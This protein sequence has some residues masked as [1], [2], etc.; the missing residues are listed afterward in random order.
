MGRAL[1]AAAALVICAGTPAA[2]LLRPGESVALTLTTEPGSLGTVVLEVTGPGPLAVTARSL[3]LDVKLAAFALLPD[4]SAPEKPLSEDDNGLAGTDARIVLRTNGPARFRLE[5]RAADPTEQARGE[6][7]LEARPGE[8]E[9]PTAEARAQADD[10]YWA[11]V[12]MWGEETSDLSLRFRA[13]LGSVGLQYA[14]GKHDAALAHAR[15]AASLAEQAYGPADGRLGVALSDLGLMLFLSGRY[16]EAAEVLPR[17]V[18]LLEDRYGAEDARTATGLNVL[19]MV[20]QETGEL[21]AAR[22]ALE[23]CLATR[24]RLFGPDASETSTALGNLASILDEMGD[25]EGSLA[26]Y[27][28]SLAII[29]RVHGPQSPRMA[30]ALNNVGYA[31]KKMGRLSEARA[32]YERALAIRESVLGTEHPLYA[33]SLQNLG[34]A[35][36]EMGDRE[37][38]VALLRRALALRER[39]LAPDHPDLAATL[40]NLARVLHDGTL[41]AEALP[42]AERALAIRRVKLGEAHPDTARVQLLHARILSALGRSA[43]AID[44]ALAAE[45]AG[46]ENARAVARFLPERL[47]LR[48]AANRA[49]GTEAAVAAALSSGAPDGAR[50]WDEVV[51]SR[52][53]VLDEMA[54]RRAALRA[55][56]APEVQ[57]ARARLTEAA[58]HWAR[59]ASGPTGKGVAEAIARAGAEREAAERA[60]AEISAAY[61]RERAA[62]DVG[63]AEV[64]RALPADAALVAYVRHDRGLAALVL[65][66]ENKP[67]R[68]V[69]LGEAA[70]LD[71]AVARWRREIAAGAV[72]DQAAARA[73]ETRA[74]TEGRDLRARIWDPVAAVLGTP[75]RVFLVPEGPLHLVPFAA[76]PSGSSS[77]LVESGPTFQYLSAERDLV[78]PGGEPA[79]QTLLALGGP[80]FDAVAGVAAAASPA[81]HRGATASCRG[82]QDLRF[83]PLPHAAREVSEVARLSGRRARVLVGPEAT[84]EAFKAWAPGSGALHLATHGFVLGDG[85]A[86]STEAPL[87]LAGLALTGANL[88]GRADR[89]DGIL[90]AEEVAA[91]DLTSVDWVALSAC[92]TGLGGIA[93]GEGV[94]GLRRAFAVAGART[95]V[96][97]LWPVD[98]RDARRWMKG[99]YGARFTRGQSAAEAARSAAREMLRERRSRDLD[100]SPFH[101]GG[102]VAAGR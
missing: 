64:A 97:T 67:V 11:A 37:Q 2:D 21:H 5:V 68:I 52:A 3:H 76:L 94:L 26:A 9:P 32:A 1:L 87:R 95:L 82:F 72:A 44:E 73:A 27:Q 80:S 75:G 83:A 99:A 90:T 93:A 59:L 71:G 78:G 50:I 86:S 35:V 28:R 51:R 23:R 49:A 40:A 29:E 46:R 34:T 100:T 60:L 55:T 102:F 66:P 61:R 14:R 98:D 92:D 38:A 18:R 17:A 22:A 89:E 57:A 54:R 7:L 12:R 19:G 84:E 41:D 13:A 31:L 58:E 43:Q 39:I 15:E 77:Y 91:L 65:P 62:R 101:W 79:P 56:E 81:L 16:A 36:N 8:P 70:P 10:A 48:Y 47:A 74:R 88:R 96:M 69:P 6:V 53:L 24:E 25:L 45:A 42:L 85:C 63:F 33:L 30:S 20:L 4:G